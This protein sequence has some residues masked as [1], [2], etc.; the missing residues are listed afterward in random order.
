MPIFVERTQIQWNSVKRAN[1]EHEIKAVTR[2]RMQSFI[3]HVR[4][5][6]AQPAIYPIHKYV[7]TEAISWVFPQKKK[8]IYKMC[9]IPSRDPTNVNSGFWPERVVGDIIPS[10]KTK[11]LPETGKEFRE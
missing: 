8:R 10:A 9:T 6:I 5:R 2:C 3:S 4:M 1:L 11:K 7:R